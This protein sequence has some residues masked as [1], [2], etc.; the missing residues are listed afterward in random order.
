MSAALITVLV[1]AFAV[2]VVLLVV[3]ALTA[4]FSSKLYRR[5]AAF[6][7]LVVLLPSSVCIRVNSVLSF[8][9]RAGPPARPDDTV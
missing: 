6:E 5:R 1:L 4:T 9:W 2:Y 8:D 7:V 3:L